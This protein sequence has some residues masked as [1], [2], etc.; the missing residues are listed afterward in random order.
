VISFFGIIYYGQSKVS[1]GV[2]HR[3]IRP[4]AF[5]TL[6]F[7][8]GAG[9]N[10]GNFDSFQTSLLAKKDPAVAINMIWMNQPN[11]C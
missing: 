6:S 4:V 1:W 9:L 11:H 2:R 7:S 8:V 10:D 3:T 5:G